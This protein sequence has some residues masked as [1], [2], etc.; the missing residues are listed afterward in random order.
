M[1]ILFPLPPTVPLPSA[2]LAAGST[3]QCADLHSILSFVSRPSLSPPL[4]PP[5]GAP[6]SVRIFTRDSA[7]PSSSSSSSSSA[8][9]PAPIARRSFFKCSAVRLV[10]NVGTNAV[11]VWTHSDVDKTNQSYYGESGLHFLAADGSFE[12]AVPL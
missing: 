1:S 10:W 7:T 12:G 8:A 11:L 4:S 2:T 9:P 6:A 3:S 5:Q